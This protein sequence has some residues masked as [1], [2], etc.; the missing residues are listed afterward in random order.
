MAGAQSQLFQ[1]MRGEDPWSQEFGSPSDFIWCRH[2]EIK[3]ELG[4]PSGL[5]K[6]LQHQPQQRLT[7]PLLKPGTTLDDH[8]S[9]SLPPRYFSFLIWLSCSYPV[10][11]EEN[12][13][14]GI[15]TCSDSVRPLAR[16][17]GGLAQDPPRTQHG[18]AQ[19]SALKSCALTLQ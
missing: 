7:G 2:Q 14:A 13:P 11:K 5:S 16:I 9:R 10:H 1:R 6:G 8:R 4:I 19:D 18:C 12:I 15:Q 17:Q 3:R